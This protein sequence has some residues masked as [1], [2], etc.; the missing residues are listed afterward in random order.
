MSAERELLRR[1]VKGGD[2]GEFSISYEI[3]FEIQELLAKPEQEITQYLLDQVAKLTA[4]NAMLKEK[5]FG[6]SEKAPSVKWIEPIDEGVKDVYRKFEW[7]PEQ[8]KTNIVEQP[9]LGMYVDILDDY[10]YL[11]TAFSNNSDPDDYSCD[12]SRAFS[13]IRKSRNWLHPLPNEE[14][15]KLISKA[16]Y[17]G[18]FDFRRFARDIEKIHGIGYPSES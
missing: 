7:Q 3:F 17:G 6:Q 9:P 4:E 1:L 8:H 18:V 13:D 10:E 2:S 11:I 12:I 14:I 5:A 15:D 16:L